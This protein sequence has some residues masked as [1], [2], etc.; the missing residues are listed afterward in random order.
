M[1]TKSKKMGR[2]THVFVV[3]LILIHKDGL[4]IFLLGKA[5][6]YDTFIELFHDRLLKKYFY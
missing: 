4:Y 2:Y 1:S 3:I 5:M 6:V